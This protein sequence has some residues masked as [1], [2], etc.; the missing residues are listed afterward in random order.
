MSGVAGWDSYKIH[1]MKPS[2]L[3]NVRAGALFGLLLTCGAVAHGQGLQPPVGTP[4]RIQGV[5]NVPPSP[6]VFR[7]PCPQNQKAVSLLEQLQANP[8]LTISEI[9]QNEARAIGCKVNPAV[10]EIIASGFGAAAG[11]EY[12]TV[13]MATPGPSIGSGVIVEADGY[14]M[15]NRHV[16]KDA[17]KITV[18]LHADG[19]PEE[20]VAAK[21]IGQDAITDLALLKIDRKDLPHL[22]LPAYRVQVR[23]GDTVYAFGS[24]HGIGISMTKGI[25]SSATIRQVD[26]GNNERDHVDYIQTDAAINSGN[27]G[28]ALVDIHGA[29]IGINTFILSSSGGNE[30]LNFAVPGDVVTHIFTELKTNGYVQRSDIGIST[31]NLSPDLI[32]AFKIPVQVGVFIVN[33]EPGSPADTAGLKVEDIVVSV[34]GR[35]IVATAD[36]ATALDRSIFGKKKGESIRL[37]VLRTGSTAPKSFNVPV[38]QLSPEPAGAAPQLTAEQIV[39]DLGI[40]ALPVPFDW[41]A[42]HGLRNPRGVIVAAKVQTMAAPQTDLQVDDVIHHVN[43]TPVSSTEE[44]RKELDRAD[45]GTAVYLQ[46]ERDHQNILIKV[47]VN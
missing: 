17:P 32:H 39:T 33:V 38:R 10:I 3:R 16:I 15:T 42:R 8:A 18:V 22:D 31:R 6:L 2:Q 34:D 47:T 27:S 41:A 26:D 9:Q 7:T 20:Q 4:P 21:L 23:Q 37:D 19:K 44:L 12:E 43:S 40:Y 36:A 46:V 24:P 29:L 25:V 28:G 11:Q 1:R 30:G 5:P 45:A 35:P 14:I 13:A